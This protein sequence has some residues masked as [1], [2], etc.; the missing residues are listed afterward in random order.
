LA[1]GLVVKEC[2][3]KDGGLRAAAY[4]TCFA[5]ELAGGILVVMGKKNREEEAAQG[6]CMEPDDAVP[7]QAANRLITVQ[8]QARHSGHMHGGT[9]CRAR[10]PVQG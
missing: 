5:Q 2:K 7:E 9:A 3:I 4:A 10:G 6:T 8:H 1:D